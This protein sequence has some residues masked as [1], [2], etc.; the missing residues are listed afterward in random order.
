MSMPMVMKKNTTTYVKTKNDDDVKRNR[1]MDYVVVMHDKGL[2]KPGE[3]WCP[4]MTLAEA[5]ADTESYIKS[6]GW[7]GRTGFVYLADGTWEI[8]HIDDVSEHAKSIDKFYPNAKW[9][10]A[11]VF[12][13][14][15]TKRIDVKREVFEM[16]YEEYMSH[17]NKVIH[18]S[19]N[20]ETFPPHEFQIEYAE[21]RNERIITQY[22]ST[23]KSAVGQESVTRF[24]KTKGVYNADLELINDSR[25]PHNHM[26]TLIYTGKP[27]VQNGWKR[28]LNH[29]DYEGWGYKNSQTENNVSFVDDETQEYIFASAQGNH[30]GKKQRYDSRIKNV[31]S[32][33]QDPEFRKNHFCK[34]ILEEC[35][36][37]LM[38]EAEREFIASLNPDCIEYV[39]GTMGEVLT[40]GIIESNDVYRF[41]LIDAMIA[42]SNNHFRFKDFP[43]P[44]FI[45]NNHAQVFTSENPENPNF[46]KALSWNGTKPNYI[47]DVDAI[48]TS[49][50]SDTGSRKEMP[51][52]ATARTCPKI[53][54]KLLKF[55]TYHGWIVVP[56]GK[57]DDDTSVGAQSTLKWY[58]ENTT[59]SHWKRYL[60]LPAS[61]GGMSE[62]DINRKQEQ[63]EFTQVLSAGALNTGTA[64]K[65]LDH[66]IWLTE[67]A[68]YNEFWQTVGRLFEMNQG[69]DIVP[70]ILPTWN[71]FIEMFKELAL[72]TQKP[73]QTFPDVTKV[74]LDMVP[75]IDWSGEPAVIDYSTM[76][77]QQLANNLKGASW[78]S[79][80]ITNYTNIQTLN[81]AE[82]ASIP[83]MKDPSKSSK[84]EDINGTNEGH[85][86]GGNVKVTVNG[87]P[88]TSTQST[89]TAKRINNFMKHMPS[90]I[91][92]AYMAGYVCYNY[93][94]LYKIPDPYFN[95]YIC[96]D[97]K[98]HFEWF[99]QRG[100]VDTNEVDKRVE[101]DRQL[102]EEAFSI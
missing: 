38:T 13:G 48:M 97:A 56:S 101:Y 60:P 31:V 100:L 58:F 69:K 39:S 43:T 94:D 50:A 81:A 52:L 42:K 70:V 93:K 1:M 21:F 26:K 76:I 74:M 25:F 27:K 55:T 28:D 11:S 83:D 65:K 96:E 92:N 79:P 73:G 87:K 4:D 63:N 18:N 59:Q 2:V 67:C 61:A 75:G 46:A 22:L 47:T 41:S 40:S 91:A 64:F 71:M 90:V 23:G 88:S 35:H 86:A 8:K 102:L 34:V 32:Q 20:I 14:A 51:L 85:N 37:Y 44:V 98:Q 19:G 30:K 24:G 29:V 95:S 17:R 12:V 68:S 82:R 6:T 33:F 89:S 84:R 66:Q 80:A 36:A 16:S 62:A 78:K 9:D 99:V 5:K 10:E 7:A 72:Y 15:D 77:Q 45:V 49:I 53:D 3:H 54:P 57:A